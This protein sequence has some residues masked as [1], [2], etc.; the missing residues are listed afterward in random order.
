MSERDKSQRKEDILHAAKEL[1][2][3][4]GI[5]SL[6]YERIANQAGLSRQLLRYYYADLDEIIV[7]LC[8]LLANR[9]RQ[10]LVAGIVDV[11]QV[12][13]LKFFLD[14][15]FDLLEDHP[16]P[17]DLEV[18]DSLVA[19]AVGSERLKDRLCGQ[20][21][22]LGQVIVHEL[23]IAHPELDG[24]RCEEL[25]YLFVS[26]M[27]AHWSFVATL[28]HSREH[29]RLTRS[30]IDRLIASYVGDPDPRAIV[31]KPWSREA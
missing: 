14:F 1:I 12:G 31:E 6:T 24:K 19:Y 28:G 25:S 30:A 20:Y 22:T 26:M 16:M 2:R 4:H 27:H 5:Q 15:F 17:D 10:L 21:L 9:Y 7:E 8:E 29:S 18:Y 23:A 3:D 13:R 11:N